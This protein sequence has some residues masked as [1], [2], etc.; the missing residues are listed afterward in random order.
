MINRPGFYLGQ[1]LGQRI[2]ALGLTITSAG[3]VYWLACYLL[4][5]RELGEFRQIVL[6]RG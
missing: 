2:F 5:C 6:G 4:R 3:A 1:P